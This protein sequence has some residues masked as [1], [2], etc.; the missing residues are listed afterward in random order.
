MQV[1]MR[2]ISRL[3]RRRARLPTKS[4]TQARIAPPFLRQSV[5]GELPAEI[6]FAAAVAVVGIMTE[7]FTVAFPVRLSDAGTLQVGTSIA[8][9]GDVTEQVRFTVPVNP[10]PGTIAT[11][12]T[13]V[14]PWTM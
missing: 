7:T 14:P 5:A 9:D 11:V 3:L 12:A 4:N 1:T 2:S 13:T 6:W 10:F 8:P